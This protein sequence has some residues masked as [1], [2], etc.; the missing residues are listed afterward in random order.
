MEKATKDKI[1]NDFSRHERDTGSS[2][3]QVALMTKRI[4][5]IGEHLNAHKKDL[6]SRRGLLILVNKR[7]KLLD[8]LKENDND[9]YTETIKRLNLRR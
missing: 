5:Q 1:R 6:S 4:A 7:R 8:Y 9:V 2:E 3:V